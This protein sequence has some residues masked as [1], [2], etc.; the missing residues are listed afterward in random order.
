[1]NSL[2]IVNPILLNTRTLV[3]HACMSSTLLLILVLANLGSQSGL[4]FTYQSQDWW[5]AREGRQQ[6]TGD[7]G[8]I[9]TYPDTIIQ[10]ESIEVDVRIEY[11]NNENAAGEY[12]VLD[13]LKVHLRDNSTRLEGEIAS[14]EPVTSPIL[15]PG[16]NYSQTFSIPAK[17][18]PLGNNY[19][20]DLSFIVSFGIKTKLESYYWDSG[21]K[22]GNSIEPWQLKPFSVIDRNSTESKYLTIGVNKPAEF[23]IVQIF[24]D[25][26]TFP[27]QNGTLV[28]EFKDNFSSNQTVNTPNNDHRIKIDEFVPLLMEDGQLV[29]RG[30]FASWTDGIKS[31]E[32]TISGDKN[33]E[34]FAIYT[35]QY[36]LNASSKDYPNNIVG[37]DDWYDA[38]STA[39]IY[40]ND[41]GSNPSQSF[42]H[43]IGDLSPDVDPSSNSISFIV[44]GPK[45]IQA[46]AKQNEFVDSFNQTFGSLA[47]F[48]YG[49]IAAAIIGPLVAWILTIV[50]SRKE[51]KRNLIY[52]RTYIPLID[53]ILKQNVTDRELSIKLIN[54]KRNEIATLLQAGIINVETYRLLNEHIADSLTE[55]NRDWDKTIL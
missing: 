19:S 23:G 8:I 38:G 11:M 15:R 36:Y 30:K 28:Y 2:T 29:M 21:E 41:S 10:N 9:F 12:A 16:D 18:L 47:E 33:E 50:Y 32:R 48:F 40:V 44:D 51:K 25:N 37:G 27:I 26:K 24:I 53:D 54:Q 3:I 31:P 45:N 20:I 22:F 13:E 43:W 17:N 35:T 6:V 34:L 5:F 39:Q 14:S 46:K 42:D 52:L 55:A 49:F 7:L 1:M 4:A